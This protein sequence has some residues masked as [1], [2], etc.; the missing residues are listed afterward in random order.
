MSKSNEEILRKTVNAQDSSIIEG[1]ESDYRGMYSKKDLLEA[2]ESYSTELRKENEKLN[3]V[4]SKLFAD[5]VSETRELQS[6][7]K[8]LAEALEKL[9]ECYDKDKHLLNFDVNIAR[10]SLILYNQTKLKL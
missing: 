2:I 5:K 3:N 1:L 7:N 9:M 10:K 6:T 8:A 4:I